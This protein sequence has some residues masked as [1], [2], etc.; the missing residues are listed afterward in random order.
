MYIYWRYIYW[1]II[2]PIKRIY[3]RW[4]TRNAPPLTSPFAI[5]M[6]KEMKNLIQD[7]QNQRQI[8]AIVEITPEM[9][10]KTKK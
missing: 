2:A 5:A 9:I 1:P 3:Y 8:K 7:I 6:D 4:R 10:A